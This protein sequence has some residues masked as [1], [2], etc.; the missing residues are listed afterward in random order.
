GLVIVS[1]INNTSTD[2]LTAGVRES[3]PTERFT[4]ACDGTVFLVYPR[5][6]A[7]EPDYGAHRRDILISKAKNIALWSLLGVLFIYMLVSNGIWRQWWAVAVALLDLGGLYV[8]WLLLQKMLKIHSR[9]ADSMCRI[10]QQ[11]GCDSVLETPAAKFFGI[12]SWSEVG[13]TY[14][15]VSLITLLLFPSHLPELALC[16]L[17]CLPFSLWS[18]WYQK[19]RAK[20]WCTLCL[21]VQATLWLLFFCYLGGGWLHEA[22]PLR[23]GF[24]ILG[25]SYATVLLA[26][27]RIMPRFE[28]N[29]N[30][31]QA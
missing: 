18:V 27:N 21:C 25:I 8:T 2:Y 3:I 29:E 23:P 20:A 22:L 24:F 5:P 28:Q 19:F 11:G 17:C 15:S 1:S 9:A 30:A 4:A 12:F 7:A 16:N 10:I 6:D 13:F 14:F 31:G 26:L